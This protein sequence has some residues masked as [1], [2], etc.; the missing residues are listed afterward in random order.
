[1]VQLS[2]QDLNKIKNLAKKLATNNPIEQALIDDAKS[3]ITLSG[4][5][6]RYQAQLY[7][8]SKALSYLE[9]ALLLLESENIAIDNSQLEKTTTNKMGLVVLEEVPADRKISILKMVRSLTGLGLKEAKEIVESAPYS[10]GELFDVE[11]AQEV[12]QQ[13]IAAGAKVSIRLTV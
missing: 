2:R 11:T 9:E 4:E 13:L 10:F 1:M 12:A 5:T 3:G 6:Q 8:Q 7:R